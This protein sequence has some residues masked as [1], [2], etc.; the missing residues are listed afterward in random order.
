M[1]YSFCEEKK[2]GIG[3]AQAQKDMGEREETY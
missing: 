1:E 3:L 2:R